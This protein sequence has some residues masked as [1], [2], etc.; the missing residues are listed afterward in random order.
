MRHR[1]A[2]TTEI[3]TAYSPQPDLEHQLAIAL[4]TSPPTSMPRVVVL[5]GC[6]GRDD[7]V[8]LRQRL[9]ERLDEHVPAKWL[10]AVAQVIDEVTQEL[11]QHT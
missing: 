11:K 3:Y 6:Q 7:L 4:D 10:A 8:E 9:L 5:P 1:K 2:T